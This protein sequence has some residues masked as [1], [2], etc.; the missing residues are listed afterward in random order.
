MIKIQPLD[1][2]SRS[3]VPRVERPEGATS[4]LRLQMLLLGAVPE[5][6]SSGEEPG[7]LGS[8]WL[9]QSLADLRP[10]CPSTTLVVGWWVWPRWGFPAS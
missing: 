10:G 4:P 7:R 2:S 6:R 9:T 5:G 3:A 8:G 1:F